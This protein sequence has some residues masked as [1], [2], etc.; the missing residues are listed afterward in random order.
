M[1]TA[2]ADTVSTILELVGVDECNPPDLHFD[3]GG[4]AAG[5]PLRLTVAPSEYMRQ[6]R[7]AC[8]RSAPARPSGL[9][10]LVEQLRIGGVELV[11]Q[12]VVVERDHFLDVANLSLR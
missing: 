7:A 11:F 4:G 10:E 12:G 5:A 9:R 1:L 3:I 8:R 6:P 2:P